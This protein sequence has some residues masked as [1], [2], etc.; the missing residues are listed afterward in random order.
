MAIAASVVVHA[1]AVGWG[2]AL[3]ERPSLAVSRSSATSDGEID[4]EPLPVEA[5]SPERR[6]PHEA[7]PSVAP[8]RAEPAAV[9]ARTDEPMREVDPVREVEPDAPAP[10]EAPL[11]ELAEAVVAPPARP[12][13]PASPVEPSPPLA[14][15]PPGAPALPA[16]GAPGEYD[17]PPGSDGAALPGVPGLPG[18]GPGAAPVWSVPGVVAA[19][20]SRPAPTRAPAA[21]FDPKAATKALGG[22]LQTSDKEK[23]VNLPA[24]GTVVSAVSTAVQGTPAP[25]NGRATFEIKLG[26]NGQVLGARVV[27]S[28]A[29]DP[30]MWDA[31]LKKAQAQIATKALAMT[32]EA[33]KSGATVRVSV[34]TRHVFPTGTGKKLELKP[35]CANGLINELAVATRKKAE[36]AVDDP[37]AIPAEIEGANPFVDASGMPCIPIGV[38][39][40]ADLS[41]IGAHRQLQ[42][43][44]QFE[45]V[46]ADARALPSS[47]DKVNKDAPWIKSDKAGPRPNNP[48]GVR[49]REQ[50][51]QKKK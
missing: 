28:S 29:G 50:K 36:Q 14:E 31:A 27:K 4:V 6:E 51:R 47:V 1:V 5:L 38:G 30:A 19:P 25:H 3:S 46:L 23:G 48:Y 16:P 42:V 37:N 2:E 7:S 34:V 22:T 13:M 21:A 41:N 20:E 45:V 49:K 43:Q 44:T 33:A 12:E 18:V 15:N 8:A 35:Q 17:L 26:P 40:T 10:P 11:P 32:G 24:A 39:G 9:A